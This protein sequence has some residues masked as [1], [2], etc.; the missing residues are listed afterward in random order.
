[1]KARLELGQRDLKKTGENKFAG[2]KYFELGDF[3]PT[4]QAIFADLGLCGLVSFT[5]D[6]ATLTITDTEDGSQV[7]ITSPMGSA[8]LKGCHE[9]QNI[10]AVETYQ[11]RY[12][13]VAAFE[14]VEHDALDATT[15]KAAP[16]AKVRSIAPGVSAT[17]KVSPTDGVWNALDDEEREFLAG[18]AANVT[19]HFAGPK[20][21]D[22][23]ADSAH[24]YL[25][26]QQL[27]GDEKA[28]LWTQ[29]GSAVRSALKRAHERSSNKEAA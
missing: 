12:L 21:T 5:A 17:G 28:A 9:V 22:S 13:W 24:A 4:A 19:D 25:A 1:M 8:A 23:E 6:T 2:Y 15:G 26:A 20:P 10:G 3:L 7:V 16:E 18:I 11:R 14:I 29:L 27:T